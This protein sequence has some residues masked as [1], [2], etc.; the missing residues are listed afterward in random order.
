MAG[1]P[2]STREQKQGLTHS[3][4]QVDSLWTIC[5]DAKLAHPFLDIHGSLNKYRLARFSYG[6]HSDMLY[7][8]MRDR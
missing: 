8:L 3:Q 1:I 6:L 7:I 5:N 4:V 2:L